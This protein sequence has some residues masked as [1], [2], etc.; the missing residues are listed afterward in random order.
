MNKDTLKPLVL[1]LKAEYFDAIRDGS[2]SEEFR[3]H[4]AHWIKRLVALPNGS[5]RD[6]SCVILRK[7]YPKRGDKSR[8]IIRPWA[9]WTLKGITHPHFGPDEVTVF[10]INVAEDAAHQA[11]EAK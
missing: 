3:L 8:E 1:N 11:K 9:G 2:K 4:N 6:Y 5:K 7:G 10:A